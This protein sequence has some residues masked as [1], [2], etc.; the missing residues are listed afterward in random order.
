MLFQVARE[1]EL[2]V[3]LEFGLKCRI[4]FF[5]LFKNLLREAQFFTEL[6]QLTL[7]VLTFY[8]EY[9]HLLLSVVLSRGRVVV[10]THL[11]NECISL[12]NVSVQLLDFLFELI[13]QRLL[14]SEVLR[15]IFSFH[16]QISD[17][18]MALRSI[19]FIA[20]DSEDVQFA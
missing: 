9:T 8:I 2:L 20:V 6:V 12:F 17:A 5:L 11:T 10:I 13:V 3:H 7:Q 15:E 4:G 19:V 16:C 1:L 14:R 18:K